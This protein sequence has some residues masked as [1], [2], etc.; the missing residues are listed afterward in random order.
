MA[1]RNGTTHVAITEPQP[2][3]V[4]KKM[5]DKESQVNWDDDGRPAVVL[6]CE[7]VV[8]AIARLDPTQWAGFVCYVLEALDDQAPDDTFLRNLRDDIEIRLDEGRW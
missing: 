2:V 5:G 4:I 7:R 3:E 1:T 8:S 6:E